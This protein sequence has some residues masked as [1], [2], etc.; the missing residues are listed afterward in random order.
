[1]TSL[2][3]NDPATCDDDI[4]MFFDPI[5]NGCLNSVDQ[6]DDQ[7]S[8]S[9]DS[10]TNEFSDE[11]L[12]DE[13]ESLFFRKLESTLS[14]SNMQM[15]EKFGKNIINIRITRNI[16]YGTFNMILVPCVAT[17]N[18]SKFHKNIPSGHCSGAI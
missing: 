8:V 14:N 5:N 6:F 7:D 10:E 2:P 13:N 1:M 18:C 15:F 4:Q 9:T 11:Y 16:R 17:Y 12:T 3:L